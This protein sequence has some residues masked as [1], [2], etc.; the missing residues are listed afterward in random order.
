MLSGFTS[1]KSANLHTYLMKTVYRQLPVVIRKRLYNKSYPGVLC[2][3]Y[4]KVELSNHIFT[5]F[6][7]S[8]FYE[9]ILV[10]AAEKW[11]SMS[12]L[13]V[14]WYAETVLVFEEQKKATLALVE[15]IRFV[16]ELHHTK[17]WAVRTKH[18]V[19]MEKTGLIGDNGLVSGLF[20]CVISRLST[21]IVYMLGVIESF[22]V[23]FS[24]H[25]LCHFFSGLN[26]NVYVSIGV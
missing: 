25:K 18:R 12:G 4:D 9:N 22:A 14:L 5:C 8:G 2:L 13:M 15:Y 3:L 23:R 20:G 24:R 11:M 1:K 19:D 6:G 17:V 26:G 16:M 10:K 21:G 7:D